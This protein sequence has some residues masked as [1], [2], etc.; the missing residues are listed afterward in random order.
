[1]SAAARTR[2][3][4]IRR[5][6][7]LFSIGIALGCSSAPSQTTPGAAGG[8][9]ASG[10]SGD[11]AIGGLDGAG[12]NEASDDVDGEALDTG[13]APF[14]DAGD[15]R[16]IDAASDADGDAGRSTGPKPNILIV[17]FDDMGFSDLGSYGGEVR[18]PRI[19]QLAAEGMRFRNFHVTPR[20]S[21]TRISLMT[22]LYTQ[23]AA[24][25]P[26]NALPPLRSDNNATIAELLQ[27]N[28][29]RTYMAGK[30]HLGTQPDQ[31]PR[32]R[33]FQHVFGFGPQGAGEGSVSK[34]DRTLYGLVSENGEI[35][36]RTYGSAP[37]EFYNADAF[38]DYALDFLNHHFAKNDGKSFFMYLAFN[39]P[40]YPVQVDKAL[41][42]K[43]PPGGMSYVDIA[44]Q[45]WDVM[46]ANRYARM[47][48]LGII[49][50][51]FALSPKS[52]T[53]FNATPAILPIPAWTTLPADRQ[54]DLIQ[55][56]AL[57]LATIEKVDTNVGRVV[58]RLSA[59][60]ALDDTLI[61]ILSDNGANAE[62]G[63]FGSAFG[64]TTP[65]TGT[66]LANMGQ[67]GQ[68]DNVLVGGGWA[69]VQSTPFRYFK[70]FTH[71]GGVRAPLIVHWPARITQR[72]S[73]ANQ[74]GHVVDLVPTMLEAAGVSHPA[75]FAGHSILP[76]EGSSL[77]PFF[78]GQPAS[79]DRK[80]GIEHES[81]RAFIDGKW[82]LV[83][84]NFA[85]TDGSSPA[86]ALELYDWTTDPTELHNLASSQPQERTTIVQ[87]WNAWATRVGVPPARLLTVP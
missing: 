42:A 67:P 11:G 33:G 58:D 50:P 48:S 46:R 73:W 83:T 8:G 61:F 32:S 85:S 72:G 38:G 16:R 60:G 56:M 78:V 20:C 45:G 71:E 53:P 34:W 80:I 87:E 1:M 7:R 57:Y 10:R 51:T 24:T 12:G 59:A 37:Y 86:N 17:L 62:G 9:D 70:H 52:D 44:S 35:A 84:K 65:L 15:A 81:N 55:R 77:M 30:W 36:P 74:Y 4:P 14:I 76:L 79:V 69:N 13:D 75:M 68:G 54:A 22:G 5:A 41:A 40:H 3:E 25:D 66:N 23:Q 31:V 63:L 18:S 43:V 27:A 28:G 64:A 82:K 26:A 6:A 49:D 39:S 19:D 29:Y 21:P 47:M 2:F